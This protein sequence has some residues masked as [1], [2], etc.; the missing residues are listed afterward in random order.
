M[1]VV[2]TDSAKN[3]N[4]VVVVGRRQAEIVPVQR[5]TG[6]A[7]ENLNA[8][9]VAEAVRFFSGVQIKDYG[10]IGGLKTVNIRAMGSQHVGV[11]YDGV[12]MGNAQNGIVDLGKFSLDNIEMVSLHNGQQSR[13]FQ[14]AKD[15]STASS[16]YLTTKQPDFQPNKRTNA[17]ASARTGSFGLVNTSTFWQQKIAEN[18]FAAVN[19]EFLQATGKYRFRHKYLALDTVMTRQNGNIQAFR[20]E[21]GLFGK[22]RGGQWNAKA[23]YYDSWRQIPGAIRKN[24]FERYHFEQQWDRNLFA[25]SS[26][27]QQI[28]ERYKIQLNVKFAADFYQ[29]KE[30]NTASSPDNIYRQREFYVS[31]VQQYA[32]LDFWNIALLADFQRNTLNSNMPNFA[33][34]ERNL[35]LVA[36]ATSLNFKR[37]QIQA[38]VLGTFAQETAKKQDIAGQAHEETEQ[39]FEKRFTPSVFANYNLL[40]NNK[41]NIYGFY[42]HIFR[43]PTFNELYYFQVGNRNL[44][45]EYATQYDVGI[46]YRADDG[47]R[48]GARPVSTKNT[49]TISLDAYFNRVSNKIVAIPITPSQWTML[50]FGKVHIFG[51]DFKAQ[52][53]VAFSENLSLNCLLTYTF[54]NAI[55]LTDRRLNYS[56]QIPYSP[57]HSGNFSANVVYKK[58]NFNY[59]FTCSGLRYTSAAN[60]NSIDGKINAWQTH[61]V[62]VF[63]HFLIKHFNTKIGFEINNIF[64][65]QYDIVKNYPMP[66]RNWKMVFNVKM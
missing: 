49:A 47:R 14:T 7:L 21:G 35:E 13:I 64:A 37:L 41:L 34:P 60:T 66:Q 28:M 33:F 20:A 31:A 23:F 59:N 8:F 56:K 12:Q 25:Q 44:K 9:S 11:F 15:F 39:R 18:V 40:K 43:L 5:L 36:L 3:L 46:E 27:T 63:Y 65:A 48:D 50:N 2:E 53:T 29:Y 4:E 1:S 10:G 32:V 16:I 52:N 6:K 24:T 54:T 62:S 26:V 61:D 57:Q 30:K 22:T 38:N 55:N 45:P 17:G 58:W 51:I 19:V 42:K